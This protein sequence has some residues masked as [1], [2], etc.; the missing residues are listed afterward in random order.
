[1]EARVQKWGNSAGI[2]IPSSILKSLLV[3]TSSFFNLTIDLVLSSNFAE[4]FDT[5]SIFLSILYFISLI[6]K[7]IV[8]FLKFIFNF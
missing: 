2:R 5:S 1:M 7:S 6:S 8:S 3:F 4:A